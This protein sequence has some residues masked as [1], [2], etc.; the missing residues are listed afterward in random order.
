[1]S[2]RGTDRP[3]GP[4][5]DLCAVVLAAGRGTRLRPLT[6]LRPKPLCPV[7]DQPLLD[8]VLGQVAALGPA[9][10]VAVA[11]NAS[12]LAEQV[13]GHLAGR[14]YLSLER[15]VP[16]GT[17]GGLARL[18]NWIGGRPVLAGNADAYLAGGNLDRLLAGWDGGTVR[19]LGVPAAPGE[20][21]TFSGF[22]FA[23]FSLLPWRWVQDLPE[24]PG[25]LV[26]AVWRPAEAAGTLRVVGY[27]GYA[28]DTGTLAGYLAANRHAAVAAGG[29][30]VGPGATVTG[31]CAESVIGAG[32][33]VRGRLTR[34]VVWPGCFVGPDEH[35]VDA[36]RARS[37][38][39]VRL[40]G[41]Q[42]GAPAQAGA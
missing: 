3:A 15:P 19:L 18:K 24:Q 29:V 36:V 16:L 17:A 30:L 42:P 41:S 6:R 34:A 27:R 4:A 23:G 10:P 26:H 32:A 14:A 40:A 2:G 35:L 33:A 20:P 8:R 11:V 31:R 1:M 12:W 7:G 28:Q 38:V 21:G 25:E 13:A 37:D 39:T 22:R 5:G 9:G